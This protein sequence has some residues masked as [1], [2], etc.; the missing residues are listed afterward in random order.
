MVEHPGNFI[1]SSRTLLRQ[2]DIFELGRNWFALVRFLCSISLLVLRSWAL[3]WRSQYRLNQS[4]TRLR[5]WGGFGFKV[6]S[7]ISDG[8]FA[9]RCVM[10]EFETFSTST[11]YLFKM[12]DWTLMLWWLRHFGEDVQKPS[13]N[14]TMAIQGFSKDTLE[15]TDVDQNS[16][17][18][19]CL[20]IHFKQNHSRW[21]LPCSLY[22]RHCTENDLTWSIHRSNPSPRPVPV[23]CPINNPRPL[24][25]RGH[26]N[27]AQRIAVSALQHL[28]FEGHCRSADLIQSRL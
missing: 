17:H 15:Y 26:P 3:F 1:S 14:M 16:H 2:V 28:P 9:V 11:N 20:I 6:Q 21:D 27:R 19:V 12:L 7:P 24:R 13:L 8:I 4:Q 10:C 23:V 18:S 22:W 5:W 25:W